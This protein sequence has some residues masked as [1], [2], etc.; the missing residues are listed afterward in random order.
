MVAVVTTLTAT[1]QRKITARVV[2]GEPKEA[3]IQATATLLKT[4]STMVANALTNA[5]GRFSMTAPQDGNYIVKVTFVGYKT[6]TRS[7]RVAN[8][9]DVS[10]GTIT[11]EPDAIMLKG[12]TVTAQL[13]KVISKED[14]LIYNAGAYMT[15]EGSVVEDLVR[16]LPGAEVDNEGNIKIN[17]K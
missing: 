13:A 16:R 5:E 2:E 12:A 7:I 1:A 6:Y 15:P 3:V 10:L 4:D 17:G 14:T 11:I 8:G 9:K